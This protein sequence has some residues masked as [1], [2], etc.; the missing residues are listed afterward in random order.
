MALAP[1]EVRLVPP[2]CFVACATVWP[3]PISTSASRSLWMIYSVVYL[4]FAAFQV[5]S[6]PVYETSTWTKNRGSRQ[7]A[8]R[9][10]ENPHNSKVIANHVCTRLHEITSNAPNR[11]T[12]SKP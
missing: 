11:V 5:S 3:W 6:V 9:F 2:I 12:G 10:I 1:A 8:C 7:S 4:C